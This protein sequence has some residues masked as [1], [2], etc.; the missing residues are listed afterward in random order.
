MGIQSKYLSSIDSLIQNLPNRLSVSL[1][2]NFAKHV[3]KICPT[4]ESLR[5]IELVER[6]INYE[7]VTGIELKKAIDA[8]QIAY[9][10]GDSAV[11]ASYAAAYAL[12]IAII[13]NYQYNAAYAANA[14]Y[15]IYANVEQRKE[16]QEY[17]LNE[18]D[19]LSELERMIYKI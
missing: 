8:A 11:H 6:W 13:S 18:I 4:P 15:D 10:N 5:C 7:N 16:Y 19:K 12:K 1:T 9:V 14:V 2:L 17:L 3:F